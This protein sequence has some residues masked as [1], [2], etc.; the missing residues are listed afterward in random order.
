MPNPNLKTYDDVRKAFDNA[1]IIDASRRELEQFLVAVGRE[2]ILNPANQARASEMGETMRQLLSA[3]QSEEL[4]NKATRI[5][6]I[7]LVVSIAAFL[8]SSAHLIVALRSPA[9]ATAAQ[10]PAR[11]P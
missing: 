9:T 11:M 8:I 7:A 2:R 1:T 10:V 6:I 3:R 5:A 4:H